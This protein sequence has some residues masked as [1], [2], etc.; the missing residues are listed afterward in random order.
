MMGKNYFFTYG[1]PRPVPPA[2]VLVLLLCT[3]GLNISF[4]SSSG[5]PIP[6]SFIVT[7]KLLSCSF[8]ETSILPELVNLIALQNK[9]RS[10]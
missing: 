10:T 9:L 5:I 3:N 6:S 8:K 1:Q 4:N 7:S 2:F